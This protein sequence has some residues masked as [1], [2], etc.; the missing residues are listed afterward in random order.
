MPHAAEP[1]LPGGSAL[2]HAEATL[3]SGARFLAAGLQAGAGVPA[4]ITGRFRAKVIGNGLRE[5]DRF[6]NVLA[7]EAAVAGGIRPARSDRN[8]ANKLR[9]LFPGQPAGEHDRLVALARARACLFY[10]S[11]M[12][13]RGD[14]RGSQWLTVGWSDPGHAGR[15]RRFAVGAEL[16]ITS[17]DVAD[18]CGFYVGIATRLRAMAGDASP[19]VQRSPSP[20]SPA[21]SVPS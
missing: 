13:T 20:P 10:C 7:D 8:T 21:S 1:P 18:I 17:E 9:T 5:L 4:P 12:V 16:A 3:R 6:L 19:S 11:G 15:L 2:A 14:V